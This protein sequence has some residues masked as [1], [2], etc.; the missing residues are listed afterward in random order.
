MNFYPKY[1]D[2]L[3][4]LF[5]FR[6]KDNYGEWTEEQE[7]ALDDE[8]EAELRKIASLKIGALIIFWVTHECQRATTPSPLD[9][10]G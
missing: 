10:K 3:L 4:I 5:I 6:S 7:N 8:I 1:A 2:P 9:A